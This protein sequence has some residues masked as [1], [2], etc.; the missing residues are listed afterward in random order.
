MVVGRPIH[1]LDSNIQTHSD[2]MNDVFISAAVIWEIAI[3]QSIGKLVVIG[4]VDSC[5]EKSNFQQLPIS[6]EHAWVTKQLPM[7]HKDPFDRM[8]VAQ[9]MVEKATIVTRDADI[10]L[11]GVPFVLA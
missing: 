11:Y 1:N 8:L 6:S 3:K 10:T 4:D 2:P 9:A 7:I 5:I